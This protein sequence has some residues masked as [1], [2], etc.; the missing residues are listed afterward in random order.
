MK[1][2]TEKSLSAKMCLSFNFCEGAIL[3]LKTEKS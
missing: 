2:K 1:L 3:K